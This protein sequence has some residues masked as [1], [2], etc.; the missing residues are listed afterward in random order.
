MDYV[1]DYPECGT[2][3]KTF[4][5]GVRARDNHC[6]ST[7]H[8]WPL[9]ECESCGDTFRSPASRLQHMEALNHFESDSRDYFAYDITCDVECNL[10]YDTFPDDDE[11]V[12]HE[13]DDHFY[14]HD[15]KR[16][17][18]NRNNLRMVR[19]HEPPISPTF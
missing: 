13:H 11:R 15:C 4:P 8:D 16:Q 3:Q 14:C 7:G 17:F 6:R 9:Y 2:C 19:W 1:A 10:C 5:A 18:Q 12:E